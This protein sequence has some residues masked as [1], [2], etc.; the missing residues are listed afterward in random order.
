MRSLTNQDVNSSFYIRAQ[1][2]PQVF[3]SRIPSFFVVKK[4]S[5][6]PLDGELLFVDHVFSGLRVFR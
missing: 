4:R 1:R 3:L 2:H 5:S 6:N